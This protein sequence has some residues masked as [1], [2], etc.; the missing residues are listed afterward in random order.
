MSFKLLDIIVLTK[1]LPEHNLKKGDIGTIVE[2]YDSN[3]FEVEF[4]RADGQTQALLTL[5]SSLIR[6]TTSKEMLSV[7][8]MA[9]IV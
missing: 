8:Q 9:E 2:V 7:R 6:S 1:N 3:N 4:I 5:D